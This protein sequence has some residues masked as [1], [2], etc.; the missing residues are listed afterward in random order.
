MK[1]LL[2][3]IGLFGLSISLSAGAAGNDELWEVTS[4]MDMPGMP[5]AMPGQT[6]KMCMQKGQAG[7]PNK[8]VP[9]NKDQDCT[10]SDV[11]MSGNTSSWKM[12][13]TGKHPMT[14]TGE[15]TRGD[16]TYSGK[17]VMHSKDGDM[18]MVYSGKRVGNCDYATEGPQAQ[19]QAMQKDIETH[20]AEDIA[21]V[22]K[23]A[24]DE[25]A[26]S[27]FLKP[28]CSWAKDAMS[29][30]MC[31]QNACPDMKPQMCDRIS[32][33]LNSDYKTISADKDAVK[34][35]GEC[36]ISVEKATRNF[37]SK[38]LASKNYEDL[39]QYCEKEARPLYDKNCAGRDYTKAM[40]SEYAPICSR[41]GKGKDN[42]ETSSG[43][44]AG[45]ES[46]STAGQVLDGAKKLKG[47]F[48][49]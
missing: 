10:M 43:S 47:L 41:F 33:G 5:F 23:K 1:Y 2:Q 35:A 3:L 19:A 6:T 34:L 46:G 21:R 25:N 20:Q 13:C 29:Q 40:S 49:F 45:S 9:K 27:H 11:R 48:G 24:V 32:R 15:I 26:Y 7:D 44:K 37:C 4:K 8:S 31:L 38:Q 30:K 22:C 36:G 12:T 39:A 42:G 16:G 14:G 18:T 17:T 28:D